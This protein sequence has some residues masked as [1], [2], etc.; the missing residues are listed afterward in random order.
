MVF[1]SNIY[2]F[3]NDHLSA[4][5]AERTMNDLTFRMADVKLSLKW[6]QPH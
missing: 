1:G 2:V 6:C 5:F 4:Y 3:F